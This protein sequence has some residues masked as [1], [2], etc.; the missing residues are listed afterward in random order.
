MGRASAGSGEGDGDA[1]GTAAAFSFAECD[2]FL[3]TKRQTRPCRHF[4]ILGRVHIS[5]S[6]VSAELFG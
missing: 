5:Q 2:G 4:L 1:A 6:P 3:N